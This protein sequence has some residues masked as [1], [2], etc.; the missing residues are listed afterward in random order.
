[1]ETIIQTIDGT[2]IVPADRHASLIS[3]LQQNAVKQG[4]QAIREVKIGEYSND[5]VGRQLISE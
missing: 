1:M 3:W 4:Q 2:Y 5:Y